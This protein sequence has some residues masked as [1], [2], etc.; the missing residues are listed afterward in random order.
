YAAQAFCNWLSRLDGRSPVHPSEE[1]PSPAVR[2]APGVP[3]FRLPTAAEWWW[4][5]Q[6]PNDHAEYPWDILP[7]DCAAP[8]MASDANND[9]SKEAIAAREWFRCYRD[10][11]TAVLLDSGRRSAEVAY[12]DDVGPFGAIGLIGNVKE[13]V[14]D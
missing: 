11:A 9:R 7:Y 10:A 1:L 6:G 14:D 5:A 3:G 13:W 12:D 4:S 2:Q 8:D